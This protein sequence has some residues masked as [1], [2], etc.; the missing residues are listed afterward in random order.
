MAPADAGRENDR[1]RAHRLGAV[2]DHR[3]RRRIDADAAARRQD[4][5]PEPPRLLQRP[6]GELVAR[7]AVRKAEIV[8]DARRRSRLA[9]GR[10]A[11]HDQG[12]QPLGC[13]VDRG[14]EAGGAA[15]DDHGV[16]LGR[17]RDRLQAEQLGELARLR[18]DANRAV[19]EPHR[20]KITL[21][22]PRHRPA[23]IRLRGVGR[24]PLE[25]D[26]VPG[27]EPPQLLAGGVP[28]MP[29]DRRPG[30]RRLGGEALQPAD[31]LGRER[32]E[33]LRDLRRRGGDGVVVPG[34]QAHHPRRFRRAKAPEEHAAEHDRDLAEDLARAAPADRALHAVDQLGDLDLPGE[35]HEE[36]ALL[37][38][39]D[40]VLSGVEMD[41]RG[42]LRDACKLGGRQPQEERNRPDLLDH[43]HGSTLAPAPGGAIVRRIGAGR[44]ARGCRWGWTFTKTPSASRLP[45]SGEVRRHGRRDALRPLGERSPVSASASRAAHPGARG[46]CSARRAGPR[47]S[48]RT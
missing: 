43:Q 42:V 34:L 4:L 17:V 28:A 2:E 37:A 24:Q 27:E 30:L 32:A 36:R 7:D 14:R 46:S 29:E 21:R 35:H 11:L 23:G 16:V 47:P 12:A 18:P 40:R 45:E 20:R 15:A 9:A 1:P 6:A 39:V 48:S 33:P 8:L 25:H 31:A 10:L 13:A 38:R 44:C 3:A 41:V 22:R 5:R 26:L 19:G